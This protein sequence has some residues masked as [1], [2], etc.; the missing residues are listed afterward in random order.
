MRKI[1]KE[2]YAAFCGGYNWRKSNTRVKV[3]SY[4]DGTKSVYVF[5]F[6][7]LIAEKII[8]NAKGI[9]SKRFFTC[10]FDTA[11]TCSRL[12]ALGARCSRKGGVIHFVDTGEA[13]QSYYTPLV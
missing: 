4:S 10:G 12:K 3:L 5:L 2:M 9:Y 6:G 13:V 11:T 7:N 8:N 1:E